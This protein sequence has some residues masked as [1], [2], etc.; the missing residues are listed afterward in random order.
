MCDAAAACPEGAITPGVEIDLLKRRG[1]GTCASICP[2]SAI[3]A[4]KK[5]TI[6]MR[7]IDIENTKKLMEFE[8]I[9]ILSHPSKFLE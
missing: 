8:G 4:G 9:I 1:C 3:S 5:L 7:E 2:F 6:H